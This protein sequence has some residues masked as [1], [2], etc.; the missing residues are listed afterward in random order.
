MDAGQTFFIS[1]QLVL[2][3]AAA[4]LA[5]FL[6]PRIRDAA[7]MLI[8][9][10]TIVAYIETVYTILK[11]FGIV[12]ED[13]LNTGSFP[14]ISFILPSMRMLFFIAAFIIMIYRHTRK[15]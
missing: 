9:F 2:G 15:T 11:Q 13:L 4:F 12:S 10:G 14:L 8:I 7:W 5:I 3:A 1:S 6:W